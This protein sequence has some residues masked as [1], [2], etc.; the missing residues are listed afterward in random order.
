MRR[1]ERKLIVVSVVVGLRYL[2]ISRFDVFR[3]MIMSRKHIRKSITFICGA[4]RYVCVYLV[5]VC[6]DK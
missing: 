1:F 5:Y 3:V 4:E 2:S 6:I